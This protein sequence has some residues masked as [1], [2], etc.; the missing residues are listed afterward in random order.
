[1][2]WSKCLPSLSKSLPPSLRKRWFIWIIMLWTLIRINRSLSYPAMIHINSQFVQFGNNWVKKFLWVPNLIWPLLAVLRIF[3]IQ[4]FLIKLLQLHA[5]AIIFLW[6]YLQLRFTSVVGS[7]WSWGYMVATS[8]IWAAW[9]HVAIP[10]E[11][12]AR[13]HCS[14]WGIINK[15]LIYYFYAML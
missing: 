15:T 14:E 1:M 5:L 9:L 10:T 4:L 7:Y 3:V 11:T 2:Q 6:F 12:W 13:C 8:Y